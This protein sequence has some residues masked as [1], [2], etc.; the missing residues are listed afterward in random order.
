MQITY[1]GHSSFKMKG[2][3]GSVVTDP[4]AQNSVGF[5]FPSVTADI[6]TVS[7]DHQDHSAVSLVKPTSK[8]DRPFLVTQ[9]GE[10]EVGGISVFGVP[11]YHDEVSG[12]LRGNNTVFTILLE[13]IRLCHLG[14]LGH[15][16]TTEQVEAI[17]GVDVL[18]VP[19]GGVF[20]LDPDAAVK[21]IRQIEPAIV[22]PMHFQTSKHESSIFGELKTVDDFLHAYG[23]EVAPV[24]KLELTTLKL[25]E[26]TEVVV[27]TPSAVSEL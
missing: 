12:A 16:L 1:L 6:V 7:H 3:S 18:F 27:L 22:I 21:V 5:A 19:V 13:G 10:Y 23:T 9:P 2:K 17:G 20:T 8:R 24:P 11:T 14:D 26:E 25:P 15:P 4:F